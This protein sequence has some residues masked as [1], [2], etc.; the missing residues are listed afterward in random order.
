MSVTEYT[1]VADLRLHSMVSGTLANLSDTEVQEEVTVAN[2]EVDAAVRASHTLPLVSI[3]QILKAAARTIASYRLMMFDG[4]QPSN[5]QDAVL[6]VRYYEVKG[7]PTVPGSGLLHQIS[8]GSLLFDV[9]IDSTSRRES[10]PIVKYRTQGG[11]DR[12]GNSY[13]VKR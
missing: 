13:G 2:E 5:T 11:C 1:T 4:F 7:D 9:A 10:A 3:P 8:K 12:T 6:Q